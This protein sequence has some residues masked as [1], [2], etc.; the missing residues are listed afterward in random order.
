MAYYYGSLAVLG[1][2]FTALVGAAALVWWSIAKRRRRGFDVI[3]SDE[4]KH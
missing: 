2:A 4:L 3:Q 1:W